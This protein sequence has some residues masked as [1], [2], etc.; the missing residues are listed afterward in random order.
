[1][2]ATTRPSPIPPQSEADFQRAVLDLARV[3]RWRTKEELLA[4]HLHEDASRSPLLGEGAEDGWLL[5]MDRRPQR[6]RLWRVQ[7]WPARRRLRRR[8]SRVVPPADRTDSERPAPRPPVPQYDVC[9][10]RSP[11]ARDAARERHAQPRPERVA[12]APREVRPWS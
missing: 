11:R 7:S 12:F 3:L 4:A 6:C 1:M 5:D 8:T 2:L 10:A 9:P